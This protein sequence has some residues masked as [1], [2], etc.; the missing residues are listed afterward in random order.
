M[1]LDHAFNEFFEAISLGAVPEGK[2]RSAWER[3]TAFLIQRLSVPNTDVF[4]QGSLANDTAVKPPTNDGDYDLDVVTVSAKPGV[5]A[6]Q[7]LEALEKVLAEDAD[8]AKRIERKAACVRL[9]Y[10]SDEE[11]RF[12]V[13]IIPARRLSGTILEVPRR[14]E[15]WHESNPQGYTQ[16]CHAQGD[17]FRRTIRM[18]KRWRDVSQGQRRGVKSIVLQVLTAQYHVGGGGDAESLVRAF[19]GINALLAS[20]PNSAPVVANPVLASENL[21]ARW[22][23][24]QYREFLSHLEKGRRLAE[25]ALGEPDERASHELWR[26]LLGED[27]PGPPARPSPRITMPP[28]RPAPDYGSRPQKAPRERYG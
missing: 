23:N 25:K 9:R 26:E 8:Y 11:G 5:T 14:G 12:H 4:L 28:P 1:R 6:E 22:S 3:L 16:W 18:L 21:T 15:G 10:A 19:Q 2:I 24:D 7:A 17:Q 13:D 27:F 20:S